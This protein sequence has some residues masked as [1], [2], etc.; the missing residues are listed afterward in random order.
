MGKTANTFTFS[1]QPSLL[2]IL[3]LAFSFPKKSQPSRGK[4]DSTLSQAF[5]PAQLIPHDTNRVTGIASSQSASFPFRWTRVTCALGTRLG[6]V[7]KIKCCDCQATYIGEIGRNLNKR[8]TEHKR[9]T[10]YGDL[11]NNIAE[12][13]LQTNHRIDWDS[14]E[15]V[16]H[17]TDYYQRLTLESWFTNLEQSPLNRCQQLPPPY[18]RLNNDTKTDRQYTELTICLTIN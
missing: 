15:C 8:L 9:A 1:K 6:A 3:G 12:H 16:I 10:R 17:S 11:N 18:K 14:A 2:F 7:Y 13:H 5:A 4:W